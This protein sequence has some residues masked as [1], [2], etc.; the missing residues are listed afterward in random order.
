MLR[1]FIKN[2]NRFKSPLSIRLRSNS[3]L[4]SQGLKDFDKNE[5]YDAIIIGGGH[6]G[7]V[8]SAYLAKEGKKVLV[9]ERRH[10]I[11]GAAVT[12]EL[13]EG[14]KYSRA[15][16]LFSLFR[17]II[18]ED[19]ELK[20][21][22]LKLYKRNPNAFTPM[23][24]GRYLLLGSDSES[25][26]KEISKFSERDAEQF[27]KY[28]EWL[29]RLVKIINP[30]LDAPPFDP[31]FSS[32]NWWSQIP[33]LYTLT[34]EVVKIAKDIPSF[35]E[36]LTAPA[37][38]IL[39]RWFDSEP[40]KATLA[41]DAVIGAMMSP[42]VPGSGYV[43]FHHIMGGVDGSPG[44]W[45]YV[46][47]GMGG[48]SECVAKA[49]VEHG[50]QIRCST[51]VEQIM[52]NNGSAYGVKL[53]DGTILQANQIISNAPIQTTFGKL[54]KEN[55][56][57]ENFT[58]HIKG[59]DYQ[60]PVCKINISLDRL[61]NFTC[62]PTENGEAGLHHQATIHLGVER[63]EQIHES[64]IDASINNI[65]SR[66]PM[67]EMT[68]PS[69]LDPTLAPK[70]HHVASLFCQYAPYAPKGKP[71]TEETRRE[72]AKSVFKTIEQYAP[73]FS[74]SILH[75]DILTPQDLEE[76]FGLPGGNIFHHSMSL[77][78]I[79]WQRPVPGYSSYTTP[80][81]SLYLCGSG[82]HPGGGVMGA[83][84]RHAAIVALQDKE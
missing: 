50:V 14:H 69:V 42:E 41:T 28:E 72:F 40:L 9:L 3:L 51:P 80:I 66:N 11:G 7:L 64:Y 24:D 75:V 15:S 82:T 12:E 48:L 61:P 58:R 53:E 10:V 16:Y 55:H 4:Y 62:L 36:L 20:K 37:S 8:C 63:C 84:G 29:N 45:A 81:S 13:Y 5:S 83:P 30:Y 60:S 46:E 54:L 59:L 68:I 17:P 57:P 49:A 27:E 52:V 70:G 21:H 65:P 38:K 6:N 32:K 26:K 22:G 33:P 76:V 77:D 56:V 44:A 25:N 35:Y 43:L 67:V 31:S 74:E 18:I 2:A 79:F 71:W 1:N 73:G 19:L 47:G 39:H 23:L 78:Q 34:K